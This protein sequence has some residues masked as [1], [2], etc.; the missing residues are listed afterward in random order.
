MT[1]L[2][3]RESTSDQPI[4]SESFQGG[5]PKLPDGTAAPHCQRCHTAL[6]FFFQLAFSASHAWSGHSVAVFACTSCADENALIP[7]MPGGKLSGA[8][9]PEE[10]LKRYG[11]NFGTIVF[12]TR[13]GRI[14]SD[15]PL[16]VEFAQLSSCQQRKSA[17]AQIGGAPV[18]VLENESPS[19]VAGATATFLF[20][21]RQ[22]IEFRTVEGAPPQMSIGL[23]GSPELGAPGHYELFLGNAIYFFGPEKPSSLIYILTQVD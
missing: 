16:R 2:L 3:C 11:T 18:W 4:D 19:K 17:F 12:E 6:T 21:L 9:V 14:Q 7:E 1:L 23:D 5:L 15:Y 20:Q 10:F 13:A 8:D 22:G